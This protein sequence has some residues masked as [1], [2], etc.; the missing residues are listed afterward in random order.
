MLGRHCP[1]DKAGQSFQLLLPQLRLATHSGMQLLL[2]DPSNLL[3]FHM[4]L[5]HSEQS[6]ERYKETVRWT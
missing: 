4:L 6:L 1:S 5:P 2:L 3:S